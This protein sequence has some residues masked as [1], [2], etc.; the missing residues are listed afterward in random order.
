MNSVG[1]NSRNV[2]NNVSIFNDSAAMSSKF[3]ECY[4]DE[5]IFM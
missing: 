2:V 5:Q 1:M 3:S 4:R